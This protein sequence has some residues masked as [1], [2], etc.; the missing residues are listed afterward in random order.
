MSE[1]ATTSDVF[2]GGRLDIL[3]PAK[4]YRAGLDAV[5][6]AAAAEIAPGRDCRV[7]DAGAG[8]GTAGLCLAAR[9]AQAHVTLVEIAAPLAALARQNVARNGLGARATVAELDLLAGAAAHEA[10]GLCA[11]S[12][13]HVIA[14]PPY[15]EE[16]RH[17]LPEDQ[18]AAGAFG[19]A[20]DGMEQWARALARLAAPGAGLTLIHRTDALGA[21]LAALDGRF[22]ALRVLPLHPRV[23]EPSHRILVAGL[24]GS[25]APLSLLPGLVLHGDGNAFTPDVAAVLRDGAPLVWR[26]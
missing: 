13:G 10:L 17:R 1:V 6:L 23:G 12:F 14:N 8:V 9:V 7:L 24:K 4:G 20:A 21:V 15:L 11:G 25:R 26:G 5:L 2:L 16:G 3:Q 19:M 22:G 18:I